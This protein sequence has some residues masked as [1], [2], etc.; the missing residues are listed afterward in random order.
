MGMLAALVI[1]GFEGSKQAV[2]ICQYVN[3]KKSKVI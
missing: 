1:K 3:C 2:I